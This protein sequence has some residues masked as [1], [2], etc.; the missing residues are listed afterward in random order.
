L[1]F[2][3]LEQDLD[4]IEAARD[5]AEAMLAEGDARVEAHLERWLGSREAY[6][7]V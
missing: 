6:L 4:L 1:R 7:G 2:A 5:C 3:D